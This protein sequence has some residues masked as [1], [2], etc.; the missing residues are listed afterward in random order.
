LRW[1]KNDIS[2]L[3]MKDTTNKISINVLFKL[4]QL[5]S[6]MLPGIAYKYLLE[7]SNLLSP[8][9]GLVVYDQRKKNEFIDE[10]MIENF[11]MKVIDKLLD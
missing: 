4:Y 5:K 8:T 9:Q 7:V 10:N 2:A 6:R 1:L 3:A 11:V